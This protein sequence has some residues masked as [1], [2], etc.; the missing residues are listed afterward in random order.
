MNKNKFLVFLFVGLFLAGLVIA[1]LWTLNGNDVY[2]TNGSVGIGTTSPM[3]NLEIA[4]TTFG[5]LTINNSA[6]DPLIQL[7]TGATTINDDWTIR[8]DVSNSDALQW[9]Y[10][11]KML[12]TMNTNGKLGIGTTSPSSR[13]TLQVGGSSVTQGMAILASDNGT[14]M[15]ITQQGIPPNENVRMRLFDSGAVK[16]NLDSNGNSFFKGGNFGIGTNSP[17]QKLDIDG[18]MRIRETSKEECNSSTAGTVAYEVVS[19]VG[20]FYGCRQVSFKSYN[21]TALH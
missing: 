3:N 9:R 15:D 19:N 21:W 16:V 18:M 4:P 5:G 2:Y 6:N 12:M 13:F 1:D 10:D 7:V 17:I 11:N 14:L 8:K 20:T